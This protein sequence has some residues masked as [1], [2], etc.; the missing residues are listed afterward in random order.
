MRKLFSISSM[1]F[2]ISSVYLLTTFGQ[3]TATL[4]LPEGAKARLGKGMVYN[5]HAR[6]KAEIRD[7]VYNNLAY[8]PDG[9]RLAVTGSIGIWIYDAR[10]GIALNLLAGDESFVFSPDGRTLASNSGG[11]RSACGT[12]IQVNSSTLSLGMK[13]VSIA[14]HSV[15][16]VK[17]WRVVVRTA[18]SVCGV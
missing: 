4:R 17:R 3:N 14:Y 6:R 12:W 18:L 1:L 2:V 5:N 9:T 13:V 8:S 10:T 16:M 11:L 15:R 7:T